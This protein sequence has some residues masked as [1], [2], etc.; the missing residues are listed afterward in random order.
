ME[1]SF[2]NPDPLTYHVNNV[3]DFDQNIVRFYKTK[4]HESL[5]SLIKQGRRDHD[6]FICVSKKWHGFVLCVPSEKQ[7][8][9]YTGAE[10]PHVTPDAMCHVFELC[11]EN[12]K[13]RRYKIRKT[14]SIFGDIKRR[15]GKRSYYIGHYKEISS[16]GLQLAALRSAPHRYSVLLEDCVEFSKEFCIQ[17]LSFSSNAREIEK[18]VEKNIKKASVTG[19]SAEHL[20]RNHVKFLG[21]F[22]NISIGGIDVANMLS[23]QRP[24]LTWAVVTVFSLLY[25]IVVLMIALK[26]TKCQL[27]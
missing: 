14:V 27:L 4:D 22:G 21:R 2:L 11:Y 9:S 17:A 5:R 7:S 19:F 1:H 3:S 25:F 10:T 13:L 23:S 6:I 12:K 24:Y 8:A 16:A 26:L 15:I 18:Q 20:S